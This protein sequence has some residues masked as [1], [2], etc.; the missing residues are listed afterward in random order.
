[1]VLGSDTGCVC[2]DD[3]GRWTPPNDL[4]FVDGGDG[5]RRSTAQN[6]GLGTRIG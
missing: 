5:C 2:G 4:E 6:A 3:A 1:V